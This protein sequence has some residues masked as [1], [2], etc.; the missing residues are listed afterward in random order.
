MLSLS[1]QASFCSNSLQL[2]RSLPL[3]FSSF[4]LCKSLA[5]LS[6]YSQCSPCSLQKL[7]LFLL[8]LLSQALC[9]SLL[10]KNVSLSSSKTPPLSPFSP[11]KKISAASLTEKIPHLKNSFQ[12]QP[13]HP[14]SSCSWPATSTETHSSL[15]IPPGVNHSL[16]PST[17]LPDS[18]KANY[19][20]TRGSL[21]LRHLSKV[22]C[23]K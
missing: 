22:S 19:E 8:L 12:R 1:S 3:W 23:R 5:P 16:A 20:V 13:R 2:L 15:K 17:L 14:L 10:L 7:P 21:R 6:S 4:F 11:Q 9:S 18:L